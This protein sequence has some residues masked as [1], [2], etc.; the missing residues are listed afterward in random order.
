MLNFHPVISPFF[1]CIVL[2]LQ[3][4]LGILFYIYNKVFTI[5]EKKNDPEDYVH[6]GVHHMCT[7]ITQL[8]GCWNIEAKAD[9]LRSY[10]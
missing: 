4:V 6:V 10:F 9:F 1:Y 2:Y 7:W 8:R 5:Y 3:I